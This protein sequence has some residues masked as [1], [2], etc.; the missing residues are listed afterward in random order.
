MIDSIFSEQIE[1][2]K[3]VFYLT[4]TLNDRR[5]EN[6]QT[7]KI[8]IWTMIAIIMI[9]MIASTKITYADAQAPAEIKISAF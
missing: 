4:L 3:A 8:T 7:K 9:Q 2:G 1:R 6:E 5:Q